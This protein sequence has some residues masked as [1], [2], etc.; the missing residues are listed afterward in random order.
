MS[1]RS[2]GIVALA[3]GG[4][5][6]AAGVA[7]AIIRHNRDVDALERRRDRYAAEL[8]RTAA[9]P[10]R[11]EVTYVQFPLRSLPRFTSAYRDGGGYTIVRTEITNRMVTGRP[12]LYPDFAAIR[13]PSDPDGYYERYADAY[14]R[15][16]ARQQRVDV[17]ALLVN[18][19]SPGPVSQVILR[20]ERFRAEAYQAVVDATD[21]NAN[22]LLTGIVRTRMVIRWK[23]PPR[24][25]GSL[26]P[27]FLIHAVWLPVKTDAQ[28]LQTDD[29]WRSFFSYIAL[30][31]RELRVRQPNGR[32]I[33][34]PIQDALSSPVVMHI[35]SS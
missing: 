1:H 6:F 13:Q 12:S 34:L 21:L 28:L 22:S 23:P 3:L 24:P 15:A 10:P 31:A 26:V 27:L 2:V 33:L 5:V 7:I 4:A 35:G 30:G 29:G 11:F 16:T 9:T 18:Q 17:V 25:R 14:A 8:R 32:A 20:V 19:V